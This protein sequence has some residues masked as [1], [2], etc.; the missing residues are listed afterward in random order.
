[1]GGSRAEQD[2]AGLLL[3]AAFRLHLSSLFSLPAFRCHSNLT[4]AQDEEKHK[5][6]ALGLKQKSAKK[7]FYLRNKIL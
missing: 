7:A 6:K 5:L 3:L 1:M 2:G 4:A